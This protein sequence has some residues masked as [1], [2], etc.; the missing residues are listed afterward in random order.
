MTRWF[1]FP[2]E[3]AR[4]S[5]TPAE[6]A[7]PGVGSHRACERETP[8]PA[9][10]PARATCETGGPRGARGTRPAPGTRGG[11]RAAGGRAEGEARPGNEWAGGLGGAVGRR[12]S[13]RKTRYS[14]V[15]G[16][17][18]SSLLKPLMV[19]MTSRGR[20]RRR[21][22]HR[23]TS[24]HAAPTDKEKPPRLRTAETGAASGAGNGFKWPPRPRPAHRAQAHSA[25]PARPLAPAPPPRP[26]LAGQP[27]GSQA[28]PRG[29][30]RAVAH[31]V[32][33]Y[34]PECCGTLTEDSEGASSQ[35]APARN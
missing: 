19:P 12:H 9:V 33:C 4:P 34:R 5:R 23:A 3:G 32:F 29:W 18:R 1:P 28:G 15:K 26:R 35:L 14:R 8:S 11:A 20:R 22:R 27:P 24:P 17:A 6:L 21:R 2:S 10:R 30:R 25:R 7:R 31:H 13:L 16:A